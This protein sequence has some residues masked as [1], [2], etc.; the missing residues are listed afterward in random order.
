MPS[1]FFQDTKT[2]NSVLIIV[3]VWAILKLLN[4]PN[5][6]SML[7]QYSNC[8][9]YYSSLLI[10]QFRHFASIAENI[11][12]HKVLRSCNHPPPFFFQLNGELF[13]LLVYSIAYID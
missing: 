5:Q 13:Y 6:W 9:Y 4:L 12:N 2:P 8:Y 3:E 11:T 1:L 10:N 7:K